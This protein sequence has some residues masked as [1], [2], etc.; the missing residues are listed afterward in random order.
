LRRLAQAFYRFATGSEL[1][2]YVEDEAVRIRPETLK[3]ILRE[4][5]ERNPEN[6]HVRN[7]PG[8][9]NEC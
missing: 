3:R 2:D 1:E 8:Q 7:M 5:R 9:V 6:R 4:C